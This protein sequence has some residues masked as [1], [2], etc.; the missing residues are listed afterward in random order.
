MAFVTNL[1]ASAD[2][3]RIAERR[4]V[5]SVFAAWAGRG[6]PFTVIVHNISETGF[7]AE[8]SS[9]LQVGDDVRLQLGKG[10]GYVSAEVVW[11][12]GWDHG[13]RF[14]T[15]ISSDEVRFAVETLTQVVGGEPDEPAATPLDGLL[16]KPKPK[17]GKLCWMVLIVA[18]LLL[19]EGYLLARWVL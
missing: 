14:L 13:C 19:L 18:A 15:P 4:S 11:R 16:A 17:G 1:D 10:A 7:R 9:E 6:A 5:N 12:D 3:R 2:N 8:F